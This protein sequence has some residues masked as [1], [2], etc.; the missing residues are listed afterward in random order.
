[1]ISSNTEELSF[2]DYWEMVKKHIWLI[3]GIVIPISILVFFYSLVS[4]KIYKAQATLAIES[5]E[6][7]I[8]ERVGDVYKNEKNTLEYFQTQINILQSRSLAERVVEALNLSKTD[9]FKDTLDPAGKL[10]SMVD[11]RQMRLSNIAVLSVTGKDPILITRIANSIAREFIQ[12]SVERSSQAAKY[13]VS[14]LESQI[15]GTMEELQVTERELNDFISKNRIVAVPDV[16]SDKETLIESLKGQKAQLEKEVT[17]ASKKYKKKH[18]KMVALETKL[19]KVNEQLET[20]IEK[21]IVLQNEITEYNVLKRRVDTLNSLYKDLLSRAKELDVSKEMGISN[22]RVVDP[23]KE[24]QKPIKPRLARDVALAFVISFFLSIAISFIIESLDATLKTSDEVELHVKTPFLGYVP[25][26]KKE[27]SDN[28][29]FWGTDKKPNSI[30]AE[31]FRNLRASLMFSFPEDKPLRAFAVTSSFPQEGKSLVAANLAIAFAQL[32]EKTLLVDADMRKGKLAERLGVKN[33]Y[34][35]SSLLT[36]DIALDKA[37]S[38]THV[39]S[40]D[41]ISTGPYAPNPT[42][43]LNSDYFK[44]ILEE[45]Q[46]KYK[47]IILDSTLLLSISEAV[48]LGDRCD[49]LVFIIKAGSTPLK[50]VTEAKKVIGKKIR[51]IGAVLNCVE[52]ERDHK[53]KY[54]YYYSESEQKQR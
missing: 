12:Q 9:E 22:I 29:I 27:F 17:E 20:E 33:E 3:V 51:I 16:E 54:N 43:L 10:L 28:D 45:L 34:G 30:F 47:R 24:P 52:F 21:F 36:S 4:P 7:N 39:P 48:I 53:Y 18:P 19:S 2:K 11:V 23:A 42:E 25:S 50:Y 26:T 37:I 8:S 49:G 40:L 46:A 41:F 14:W 5:A 35:L 38:S 13:G 6:V 15:S 31:S 32:G 44:K 1:M